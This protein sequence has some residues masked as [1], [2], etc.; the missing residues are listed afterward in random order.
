KLPDIKLSTIVFLG[1]PA[2]HIIHSPQLLFLLLLVLVTSSLE[3]CNS[4]ATDSNSILFCRFSMNSSFLSFI[5]ISSLF[6]GHLNF[7]SSYADDSLPSS[8]NSLTISSFIYPQTK[9]RP[10]DWRYIRVDI[11]QWFSSVSVEL[12]S[13]VDLDTNHVSRISR[14]ALRLL[15]L[16][17]SGLP[18]PDLSNNS[19]HNLVLESFS[20]KSL[21]EYHGLQNGEHC[22]PMQRMINLYLTNEQIL[23][24]VWYLGLFNGLGAMRTQSKMASIVRGS[25]YSFSANISLEGCISQNSWGQY[26]NQTIESLSCAQS[27]MKTSSE[28]D[29]VA[30]MQNQTA[31]F[32]I[33]CRSS[34][35]EFCLENS[36]QK[37]FSME[38]FSPAQELIVQASGVRLNGTLSLNGTA[39]SSG[40]ELMC[41]ARYGAMPSELMHD[42]ATDINKSPL[43]VQSPNLGNW[44][45]IVT[46]GNATE[47]MGKDHTNSGKICFSLD[48]LVVRCPEG[49]AGFNCSWEIHKLQTVLHKNPPAPF[50]CNYIPIGGDVSITSANFPLEPFL[51]NS[52]TRNSS[53]VAWTYFT[54]DIPH[55]AAGGNMHVRLNSNNEINYEIYARFGGLPSH[56]IWDYFYVS[57]SN[58]SDGSM[59]FMANN[60]SKEVVDFYI[61]FIREG[62][63]N[64]GIKQ[65]DSSNRVSSDETEMFISLERCPNKCSSPHGSCTNF[66]DESG[67]AVYSYCSCD[68]THGG[69]DC[70]VEI[71]SHRGHMCQSVALIASNA[72]AI[73]PAYW[74]LRQRAFPEWVV[75]TSSGISS[76]LYHACDVGTWCA[77]NF[78]VLQFMD[79][80]LS[81]MA[82]VSTFVYLASIDEA[83]RRTIHAAVSILTALIAISGATRSANIVLV[84]AI[85][86]TGLVIGWLIELFTKYRSMS[87]STVS[88]FNFMHG[89]VIMDSLRNGLKK[90]LKRFQWG[91]VVAGILALT[92]AVVSW[93][94]ETSRTYWIWHSIWHMSIYT[95]SFL[96]LCSKATPVNT[97]NE[98]PSGSQTRNYN[99]ASQDPMAGGV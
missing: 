82:V 47:F 17:Y 86:A 95:T 27:Y 61:L 18:L 97:E 48:W 16:R 60:S 62:T 34:V 77:L 13:D 7:Y 25:A 76:G 14:S 53:Q 40:F 51:S 4:T 8:F 5:F 96:F 55:G 65:S 32:V 94:L 83:S 84:I 11:P 58:N 39:N 23:P 45:V 12:E 22:Y 31:E 54:L 29:S 71:I 33:P 10:F 1:T 28:F 79:F 72:A 81:F 20:N 66:M 80:W 87:F 21:R 59:F 99:L 42:Y 64:L 73:L 2:R 57:K 98:R 69:F 63:W 93:T 9:L 68:R 6:L 46:P 37:L 44:Y 67:L 26:C 38:M 36:E 15:C 19:L 92:L 70:S 52:S 88:C 74:A 75:Y 49:K 78:R 89:Q 3:F 35:E 30:D 43:I 90:L 24:G 85:G 91:F 50:E 41:Y 56:D